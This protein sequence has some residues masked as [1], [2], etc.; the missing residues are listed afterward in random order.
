MVF[1]ATSDTVSLFQLSPGRTDSQHLV[2]L[3]S[4]QKRNLKNK[5]K[6]K[7]TTKLTSTGVSVGKGRH[8]LLARVHTFTDPLEISVEVLEIDLPNYLGISHVYAY[9]KDS[10]SYYRGTYSPK[11]I[12]AQVKIAEKWTNKI[13]YI[14]TRFFF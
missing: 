3:N 9:S 10:I 2:I 12:A 13:W 4:I 11:F 6:G 14:F 5:Q 7:Q 8:I 1:K